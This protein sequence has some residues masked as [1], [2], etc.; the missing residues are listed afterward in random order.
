MSR[1]TTLSNGVETVFYGTRVQFSFHLPFGLRPSSRATG[2]KINEIVSVNQQIRLHSFFKRVS[3]FAQ[4]YLRIL[5]EQVRRFRCVSEHPLL[6]LPPFLRDAAR[7]PALA[8]DW[9]SSKPRQ[10][11]GL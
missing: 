9:L 4:R 7:L 1:S 2:T 5:G 10:D 3:C 11:G 6:E 8:A